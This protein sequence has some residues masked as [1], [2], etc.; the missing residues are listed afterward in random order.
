M[1]PSQLLGSDLYKQAAV[2]ESQDLSL[3]ARDKKWAWRRIQV[4]DTIPRGL[5][6]PPKLSQGTRESVLGRRV[7]IEQLTSASGFRGATLNS[8][9]NCSNFTTQQYS[10]SKSGKHCTNTCTYSVKRRSA[11]TIRKSVPHYKPFKLL[12]V[13]REKEMTT[14]QILFFK[15]GLA[16]IS[17]Y[18]SVRSSQWNLRLASIKN[19]VPMFAALWSP[20][21]S[22]TTS[23]TH[24][25]PASGSSWDCESSERWWILQRA[26]LE[27]F[28]MMWLFWMKHTKCMI[29]KDMVIH[30]QTI[31]GAPSANGWFPSTRSLLSPKSDWTGPSISNYIVFGH[32][33]TFYG[34]I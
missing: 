11:T 3:H 22:Q 25:R 1:I 23:T 33:F 18:M 28:I 29:N 21:L 24:C 19:M 5:P 27:G 20:K 26:Y 2:P 30:R 10:F 7:L 17:M 15:N 13:R 34:C 32:L 6:H 9:Q 4:G 12:L 14:G 31:Q 8:L 16:F